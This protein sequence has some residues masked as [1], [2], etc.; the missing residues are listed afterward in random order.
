ML[1]SMLPSQYY[2]EDTYYLDFKSIF[3]LPKMKKSFL[4]YLKK[5][6]K[7]NLFIFL[8]EVTSFEKLKQPKPLI[9]KFDQIYKTYVDQN[10]SSHISEFSGNIVEEIQKLHQEQMNP[11]YSN[12]WVLNESPNE[13]FRK[14]KKVVEKVLDSIHFSEFSKTDSCIEIIKQFPRNDQ[15]LFSPMTVY[16][17]QDEDF[18]TPVI[19]END[20]KF[21]K[22][23]MYKSFEWPTE[24]LKCEKAIESSFSYSS[25]NFVGNLSLIDKAVIIKYD[26]TLPYA[27]ERCMNVLTSI[28]SISTL[29]PNYERV[30]ILKYHSDIELKKKHK[31]WKKPCGFLEIE[32]DIQ[33]P[34]PMNEPR[35]YFHLI[36]Y[37]YDPNTTTV[38]KMVKPFIHES[39]KGLNYNEKVKCE[40]KTKNGVEIK[41]CYL[42]FTYSIAI[43]RKIGDNATQFQSLNI[44]SPNG[45]GSIIKDS[46]LAVQSVAQKRG[47][48]Q[49]ESMINAIE[50]SDVNSNL[51]NLNTKDYGNFLIDKLNIIEEDKKFEDNMQKLEESVRRR[52]RDSLSGSRVNHNINYEEH[53][54]RCSCID[55]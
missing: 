37:D 5:E 33:F 34:F 50:K 7:T 52:M 44:F 14:A 9:K 10:S 24:H 41:D 49:V 17:Y 35:K 45:W 6:K 55:E 47:A 26:Y 3:T 36:G 23:L 30:D 51:E 2:D 27:F 53:L 12:L 42:L 15:R 1:H 19:S 38:I 39:I 48:K 28:D 46:S 21:M 16:T 18:F 54:H 11:I 32:A 31:K 29:D 13:I 25:D 40:F 22:D 43:Y 20:W 8:E 4:S